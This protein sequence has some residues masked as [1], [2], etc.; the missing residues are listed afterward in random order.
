M[1]KQNTL[2]H[3]ENNNKVHSFSDLAEALGALQRVCGFNRNHNDIFLTCIAAAHEHGSGE[4][5]ASFAELGAR[6]TSEVQPFKKNMDAAEQNRRRRALGEKFK[7][8]YKKLEA[9]QKATGLWFV[10]VKSGG[11]ERGKKFKSLLRVEVDAITQTI[12]LARQRKDFEQ[13]RLRCFEFAAEQVRDNMPR[14]HIQTTPYLRGAYREESIYVKIKRFE[15]TIRGYAR[16]IYECA[17]REGFS[18]DE[19]NSLKERLQQNIGFWFEVTFPA[20]FEAEKVHSSDPHTSSIRGTDLCTGGDISQDE[21]FAPPV[22]LNGSVSEPMMNDTAVDENPLTD[23][24]RTLDIVKSIGAWRS[25]VILIDD[26]SKDSKVLAKEA[27]LDA[28]KVDFPK[29]L[30]QSEREQKSL[31]VDLKPNGRRI[32][33]VDEANSEVMQMLA[34]VSFMTVETSK[35]NGQVWVALPTDL[36]DSEIGAIKERLFVVLKAKGANKGASGGLRWVGTHNFKPERK[37]DDGSF[38]R[39]RLLACNE[40]RITNATELES[41]GL[42]AEPQPKPLLRSKGSDVRQSNKAK[43][44][45]SYDYAAGCVRRKENG[46]IDRSGIDLLYAV[47]CLN[48]DFTESETLDLLN[49]HSAKA[50]ERRDNYA[51][52]VVASASQLAKP[53]G[54]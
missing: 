3:T 33:Q 17:E 12:E 46:D 31:V 53:A 48:W 34:P 32:I 37:A 14:Q 43:R 5:H 6:M 20:A 26:S 42:L 19:F 29:W 44:E 25:T 36:G 23:A 27:T 38:P 9:D 28:V 45:P 22:I 18:A 47:T 30:E 4:F 40:G 11:I 41:F 35:G 51:E 2:D 54:I 13:F 10:K 1:E 7:R 8:A 21:N 39:V 15:S 24:I 49:T 16:K 50:K 52:T